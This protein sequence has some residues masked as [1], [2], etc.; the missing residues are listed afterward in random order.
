MLCVFAAGAGAQTLPRVR[1][2][3]APEP[4]KELAG[5]NVPPPMIT[6]TADDVVSHVGLQ[7][8]VGAAALGED[9]V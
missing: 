2:T 1:A 7:D 5:A 4:P 6:L 8:R 9:K 3:P